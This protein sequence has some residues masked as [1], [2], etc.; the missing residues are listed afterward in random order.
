VTAIDGKAIAEAAR[1]IIARHG[2]VNVNVMFRRRV[3]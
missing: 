3:E 1:G 2:S